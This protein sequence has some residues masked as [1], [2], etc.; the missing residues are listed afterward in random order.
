VPCYR[1]IQAPKSLNHRYIEE[2]V[3]CSLVPIQQLARKARLE[4]PMI[5]SVISFAS[6]L[7]AFE[8]STDGRTLERLG[9]SHL[10]HKEIMQSINE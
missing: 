5:D 2:D 9:L 1:S 4:T 10:S 3:S 7:M 6:A 8:F